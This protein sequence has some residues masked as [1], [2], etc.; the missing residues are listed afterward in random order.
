MK[1]LRNSFLSPQSTFEGISQSSLFEFSSA[2]TRPSGQSL[3]SDFPIKPKLKSF[4]DMFLIC[5]STKG[6]EGLYVRQNIISSNLLSWVNSFS[7]TK[8]FTYN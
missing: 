6:P 4:I 7:I 8:R 1:N 3:V 2:N 5:I